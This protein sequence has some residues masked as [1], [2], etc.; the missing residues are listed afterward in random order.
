MSL[1]EVVF[2]DW[3][4]VSGLLLLEPSVVSLSASWRINEIMSLKW[5]SEE[6]CPF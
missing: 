3:T 2:A 4:K 5:L 1:E 6:H